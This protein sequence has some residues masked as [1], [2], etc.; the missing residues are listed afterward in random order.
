[1]LVCLPTV[2]VVPLGVRAEV[3]KLAVSSRT[4][5]LGAIVAAGVNLAAD[6]V[7]GSVVACHKHLVPSVAVITGSGTAQ[8]SVPLGHHHGEVTNCTKD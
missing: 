2:D 5:A 4:A 6:H 8:T 7:R 1:M 3:A